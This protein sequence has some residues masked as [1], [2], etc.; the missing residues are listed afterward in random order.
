MGF[1]NEGQILT[2]SDYVAPALPLALKPSPQTPMLT[3]QASPSANGSVTPASGGYYAASATIPVTAT[4]NAGFHFI[5]WTSTGGDVCLVNLGQH[6]FHHAQ[7]T[8]DRNGELWDLHNLGHTAIGDDSHRARGH[9]SD[10]ADIRGWP[11]RR[12]VAYL[13][14]QSTSLHLHDQSELGHVLT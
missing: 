5:N 8:G 1:E 7:R 14:R 13:R 4:A 10:Y 3:K 2:A 6:Q 11:D 9:L 12:R